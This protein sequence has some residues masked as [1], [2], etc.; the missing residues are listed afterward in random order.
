MGELS[1]A[2]LP[3]CAELLDSSFVSNAGAPGERPAVDVLAGASSEAS[4]DLSPSF[5]ASRSEVITSTPSEH[6]RQNEKGKAL[7]PS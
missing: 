5:W 2:I 6:S 7:V 3:N 4:F 1:G